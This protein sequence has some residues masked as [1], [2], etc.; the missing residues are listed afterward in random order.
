[1]CYSKSFVAM[2]A[3]AALS[4]FALSCSKEDPAEPEPQEPAK[5]YSFSA[6]V[7]TIAENSVEIA[8]QAGANVTNVKYACGSIFTYTQDLE[9]FQNGALADTYTVSAADGKFSVYPQEGASVVIYVRSIQDNDEQGD[10]ICLKA[11]TGP[12]AYEISNV[13]LGGFVYT[14][15]SNIEGYIGMSMYAMDAAAPEE[16][17]MSAQEIFDMLSWGFVPTEPGASALVELNGDPNFAMILGIYFWKEDY[18]YDLKMVNFSTGS[19]IENAEAASIEVKVQNITSQSAELVFTPSEA[20]CG[21]FYKLYKK[22]DYEAELA[23]GVKFGYDPSI[24]Y[25]REIASAGG[26][27]NYGNYSETRSPLEAGTDYVL[28]C[29]PF[30]VNGSKGWGESKVVEFKTAN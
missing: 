23:E 8:F 27:F 15:P 30:N 4:I 12:V 24:N 2:L 5:D 18:T 3:T 29:F 11:V 22:A 17:F 16:W 14:V 19:V 20:T 21:Y 25:V 6:E 9:K 10:V 28:A 13:S 1:M 26:G 7:K